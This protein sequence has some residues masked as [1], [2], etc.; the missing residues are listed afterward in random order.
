MLTAFELSSRTAAARWQAGTVGEL[1]GELAR[2]AGIKGEIELEQ[3]AALQ[4]RLMAEIFGGEPGGEGWRRMYSESLE[5][6]VRYLERALT[7]NIF[8]ARDAG[9]GLRASVGY[10]VAELEAA[11]RREAQLRADCDREKATVLELSVVQGRVGEL[12]AERDV[13]T[14]EREAMSDQLRRAEAN[15]AVIVGSRSW[16]YTAAIRAAARR[17]RARL[18]RA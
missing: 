2:I 11:Q 18:Q 13:A 6:N 14:A 16:R 9:P 1:V 12:L 5:A 4:A 3:G 7:E 15:L 17:L 10:A 8:D